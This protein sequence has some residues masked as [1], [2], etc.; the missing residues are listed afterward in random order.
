MSAAITTVLPVPVRDYPF[1]RIAERSNRQV[2]VE[3]FVAYGDPVFAEHFPE[4]AVL[5]GSYLLG[6]AVAAAAQ[7]LDNTVGYRAEI[8][9]AVFMRPVEPGDILLVTAERMP[10]PDDSAARATFRFSAET[11]HDSRPYAEGI[12]ALVTEELP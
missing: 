3:R 5:P 8:V 11:R 6:T 9:R 7:L 2:R 12:V 1:D 4:R 10:R